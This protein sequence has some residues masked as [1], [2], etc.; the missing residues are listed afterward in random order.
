[1]DF[2]SIPLT[3]FKGIIEI[4]LMG[5]ELTD[6]EGRVYDAALDWA[7]AHFTLVK[8][9]KKSE[10]TKQTYS[11]FKDAGDFLTKATKEFGLT[12]AKIC[13]LTGVKDVKEI[14][15]FEVAWLDLK[16]AVKQE[17][18]ESGG[19]EAQEEMPFD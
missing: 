2:N 4:V 13:E 1:M 7:L 12:K 11:D 8:G 3:G 18:P 19:Q 17:K 15:S 9:A 5:R 6:K 14:A 10:P 16:E